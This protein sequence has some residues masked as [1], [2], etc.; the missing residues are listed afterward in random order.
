MK[1]LLPAPPCPLLQNTRIWSTKF[2]FSIGGKGT[3]CNGQGAEVQGPEKYPNFMQSMKLLRIF[4]NKFVLASIL[5]VGWMLFFD[6][7]NLF[8]HLQ[9]RAELND[10]KE[11]K[12]YYKDQIEKTKN[13]IDLIKTNPL[14]MEK[15][16][17]EQY[18][19][20]RDNEDIF[21]VREK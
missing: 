17:R 12:Q 20:K 10:L 2:D 4:K 8:L 16:A 9:Y 3:K 1:C 7:N 15:I 13:D 6:H 14:W 21:L 5:F 11:R 19:M 18:L